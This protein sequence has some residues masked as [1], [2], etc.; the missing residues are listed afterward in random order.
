VRQILVS[1]TVQTKWEKLPFQRG[2]QQHRSFY[3]VLVIL[4]QRAREAGKKWVE[5]VKNEQTTVTDKM[6][7]GDQVKK[8]WRVRSKYR[9][10]L[11]EGK[12]TFFVEVVNMV[13]MIA[14]YNPG[15]VK[16]VDLYDSVLFYFKYP[17]WGPV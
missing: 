13:F 11:F 5:N 9:I 15:S 17:G 4:Y 6:I 2:F 16:Y 12:N 8:K 1:F 7:A 14:I 10:V 3:F